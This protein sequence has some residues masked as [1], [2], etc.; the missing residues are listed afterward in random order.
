MDNN[1][2]SPIK[3][4]KMVANADRKETTPEIIFVVIGHLSVLF[5]YYG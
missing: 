1:Q 5:Y 3:I 4:R 2:S